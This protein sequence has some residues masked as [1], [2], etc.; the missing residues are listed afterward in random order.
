MIDALEAYTMIKRS[1]VPNFFLAMMTGLYINDSND[2][3]W[4]IHNIKGNNK[5]NVVIEGHT[6]TACNSLPNWISE[7]DDRDFYEEKTVGIEA[8][9]DD[10]DTLYKKILKRVHWTSPIILYD[11]SLSLHSDEKYFSSDKWANKVLTFYMSIVMKMLYDASSTFYENTAYFND[12]SA[13]NYITTHESSISSF[14]QIRRTE[15]YLNIKMYCTPAVCYDEKLNIYRFIYL[16]KNA[17]LISHHPI[18]TNSGESVEDVYYKYDDASIASFIMNIMKTLYT[19][20]I[21]TEISTHGMRYINGVRYLVFSTNGPMVSSCVAIYNTAPYSVG[22]KSNPLILTNSIHSLNPDILQYVVI[23]YIPRDDIDYII[24]GYVEIKSSFYDNCL[25]GRRNT[26]EKA[27]S[28]AISKDNN[29]FENGKKRFQYRF[30][31][32]SLE[33]GIIRIIVTKRGDSSKQ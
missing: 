27:L 30:S 4:F 21:P 19:Q 11:I 7:L 25:K 17:F 20:H 3:D 33:N 13:L 6:S 26:I 14:Y 28:Y 29:P 10:T 12:E 23:N 24:L 31:V 9:L 8:V 22:D 2:I 5:S 15:Q 1:H 16:G 18:E 32:I